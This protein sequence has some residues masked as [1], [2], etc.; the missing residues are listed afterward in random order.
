MPSLRLSI[1]EMPAELSCSISEVEMFLSLRTHASRQ[2]QQ[3]FAIVRDVLA[4]GAASNISSS[5]CETPNRIIAN[6]SN[7]MFKHFS[8]PKF[9]FH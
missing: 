2:V 8:F 7:M 1:H 5:F 4:R 3:S 9:A 6:G